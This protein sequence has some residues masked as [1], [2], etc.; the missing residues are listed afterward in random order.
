MAFLF[1][2]NVLPTKSVLPKPMFL[3]S[4]KMPKKVQTGPEPTKHIL[5]FCLLCFLLYDG[6]RFVCCFCCYVCMCFCVS[7]Y[8]C[9]FYIL[10]PILPYPILPY[11]TLSYPT[12]SY[13][14]LSYPTLSCP[15]LSCPIL[16]YPILSSKFCTRTR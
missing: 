2:F 9:F 6:V 7:M 10:Y 3:T 13:P 1:F 8:V 16:P 15:V 12:L 4:Q 11:P 14:S 5:L